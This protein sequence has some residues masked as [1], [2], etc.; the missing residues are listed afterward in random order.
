STRL[1]LIS[2]GAMAAKYGSGWNDRLGAGWTGTA[3]AHPR[4]FAPND[5][6]A[7]AT[8]FRK[9]M[10]PAA[11]STQITGQVGSN[12]HQCVPKLARAAWVWWLLCRP[13]PIM[14]RSKGIRFLLV[15]SVG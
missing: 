1:P 5:E 4:W 9:R 13:S 7:Q 2:V 15:L 3:A 6:Q 11:F 8:A 14:I 10:I 12:S